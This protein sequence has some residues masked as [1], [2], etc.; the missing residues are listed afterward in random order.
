MTAPERKPLREDELEPLLARERVTSS[1][2]AREESLD[3]STLSAL[4]VLRDERH[5]LSV[6]LKRAQP[7]LDLD[8]LIGRAL[9][10]VESPRISL[11]QLAWSSSATLALALGIVFLPWLALGDA[12]SGT[13]VTHPLETLRTVWVVGQATDR[14]LAFVPG[15]WVTAW[16][17]AAMIAVATTLMLRKLDLKLS[18]FAAVALVFAIG[19]PVEAQVPTCNATVHVEHAPLSVALR[20]ATQSCGLGVMAQLSS[21]PDTTLHVENVPLSVV[22]EVLLEGREVEVSSREGLLAIRQVTRSTAPMLAP[23]SAPSPV[24]A[25]PS[26]MP[27]AVPTLPALPPSR[28]HYPD[29]ISFGDDAHVT[30]EQMVR[31]VVTM[32]GDAV[33]DGHVLG[34]VVTTG[35]DV[36]VR[37]QVVGDV[38]T[39]GGDITLARGA[40]VHGQLHSMGGDVHGAMPAPP[41]PLA[42]AVAVHEDDVSRD[43]ARS[44]RDVV[45]AG[46]RAF[47]LALHFALIFLAGLLML[48]FAPERVT[49]MER[50][51][52]EQP[53]L[54]F[55]WGVVGSFSLTMLSILLVLTIIGIP[56]ALG[57]MVVA[58]LAGYVG[59]AV[60]GHLVGS[61]LPVP[62]LARR[63]IVQLFAGVAIL[64]GTSLVPW[65][66]SLVIGSLVIVGFGMVAASRFGAAR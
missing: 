57:A 52:R 45:E 2:L 64:F 5:A 29:V 9:A 48:A 12:S 46:E 56:V 25:P 18:G 43:L 54:T 34:N 50:R 31:D 39:M 22:L 17:S 58:L 36:D 35:G 28:A 41:P 42:H 62:A 6:A 21:D 30:R 59:L 23:P 61:V 14:M 4:E 15:G 7:E 60:I 47:D 19:G 1:D 11:R 33:I 10:T 55:L 32:G 3:D 49:A 24:A 20:Q 8:L 53:G 27:P 13:H 65:I 26:A 40:V 66:G 63:P 38:L 44:L 16:M 37:G 51:V